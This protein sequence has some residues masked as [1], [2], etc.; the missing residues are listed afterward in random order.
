VQTVV[1]LNGCSFTFS[2]SGERPFEIGLEIFVLKLKLMHRGFLI[3]KKSQLN[4]LLNGM[5]VN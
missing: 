4:W 3:E 5:H 2:G 1:K